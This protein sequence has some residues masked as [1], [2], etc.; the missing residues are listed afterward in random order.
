MG[1]SYCLVSNKTHKKLC[2]ITFNNADLL[3]NSY[4]SMYILEPAETKQV[5]AASDPFGLKVA[6][7]YDA[8]PDGQK[9]IYQRWVVK[10]EA[11]LTIT[12]V[13]GENIQY[14]GEG[15]DIS[16]KGSLKEKDSSQFA[17]VIDALTFQSP[18]ERS[19]L[20]R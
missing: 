14:F 1:N 16:G 17:V 11:V 5:E 6:I 2:I 13:D 8:A 3:Y 4:H 15:T 9:I 20:R 10:K 19:T 12:A 18:I 7:V